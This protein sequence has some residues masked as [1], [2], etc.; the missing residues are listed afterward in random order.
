MRS[1]DVVRDVITVE[2]K[3]EGAVVRRR[4]GVLAGPTIDPQRLSPSEYSPRGKLT[5][6]LNKLILKTI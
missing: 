3:R 4:R 1:E 6:D 2:V 5:L